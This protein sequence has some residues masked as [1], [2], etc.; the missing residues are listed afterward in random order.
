M[1][2]L[3]IQFQY[4]SRNDI[5]AIYQSSAWSQDPEYLMQTYR[6]K[7]VQCL[8]LGKYT[9]SVPY[10]IQTLLL[11][12]TIEHFRSKDIQVGAWGLLGMIVRIAMR[13]GTSDSNLDFLFEG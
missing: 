10:S 13:M 9:K 3:A 1:M 6:Q 11:Y 8:V 7:I 2:C 12:F 4:L 5:G